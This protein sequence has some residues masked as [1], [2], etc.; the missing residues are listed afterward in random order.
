[1]Y[2]D[3]SRFVLNHVDVSRLLPHCGREGFSHLG[4]SI[5][6][7]IIKNPEFHDSDDWNTVRDALV[8][9]NSLLCLYSRQ[10]GESSNAVKLFDELP[11]RDIVSWNTVMSGFVRNGQFDIG[12]RYLKQ[13]RQLGFPAFNQATLTTLLSSLD[14]PKF[15]RMNK[16]VH[17]LVFCSGYSNETTVGNSL[18]TSY[19]KCGCA[20]S[21]RLVFD[22]M[23]EK[24]VITWTATISGL[25]QNE[26]YRKSLEL[27]SL[28]RR[29]TLSPNLLTYLSSLVACSGLKALNEGRQIHA[30][31]WKF[32]TESDLRVESALMDMY[33]KCGGIED[34]Q[35]VFETAE[36]LD[37]IAMTVILVGLAQNGLE[38]EAIKIFKKMVD[39][40]IEIDPSVV[41]AALGVFGNYTSLRL[42]KQIHALIAKKNFGDNPYVGNGL[43][44]MY[45][46]CGELGESGKVFDEMP[47]RNLVS[48]NSLISA[49][50][51][52]GDGF[53][54]LRLYEDMKRESVKPCD[55]TFLSLIHACSHVGLVEKGMEFLKSMVEDYGMAPRSEHYASVVDMLG[56]AG[57]LHEAKA[58]IERLAQKPSPLVWQSMLGACSFHPDP[59]LGK[60]AA[61]ELALAMPENP[62]SNVLLANIYSSKGHWKE[63]ART[64]KKMKEM[65]VAKETGFSW[66]EIENKVHSFVVSDND[67]PCV[68][69]IY[70]VL[71]ELYRLMTDQGYVPNHR[72][73][74]SG[75]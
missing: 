4:Y 17:C 48:W 63:R 30:L 31:L 44:N 47:Q 15:L 10:N 36:D 13:I 68:E 35:Q 64:L 34:A 2:E 38:E 58:F 29:E 71:E 26:S 22:E 69:A 56:R 46:K 12:F 72:L 49:F 39:S 7:S 8:V 55:V 25:A 14:R 42:G 20:S 6:A 23:T 66:I 1:M 65:G 40:G 57:L 70:G 18:I 16:M 62:A 53:G 61:E 32:G 74:S 27:F 3:P 67:H 9:W 11:D 54:A 59:E 33:S 45:S 73:K 21:G 52:H 19:F 37:E 43:I 75:L 60:A 28:M 24:N 50:A 41:S 51:R 5:H